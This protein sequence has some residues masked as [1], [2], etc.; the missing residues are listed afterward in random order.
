MDESWKLLANV[1]K[2]SKFPPS[3]KKRWHLLDDCENIDLYKMANCRFGDSDHFCPDLLPFTEISHI[4]VFQWVISRLVTKDI[5][6]SKFVHFTQY[7]QK[8]YFFSPICKLPNLD[9]GSDSTMNPDGTLNS[10]R[11][12]GTAGIRWKKGS[13]QSGSELRKSHKNGHPWYNSKKA[14]TMSI[15]ALNFS[16]RERNACSWWLFQILKQIRPIYN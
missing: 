10:H 4:E 11:S 3:C 6:I 16:S 8:Q 2:Y 1:A 5:S 13:D 15:L 7:R 12:V 14:K 9:C